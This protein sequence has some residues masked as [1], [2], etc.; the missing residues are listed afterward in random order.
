[1][2]FWALNEVDEFDWIWMDFDGCEWILMDFDE[3][4]WIWM[5][6]D[7]LDGF[8]LIWTELNVEWIWMDLNG[9]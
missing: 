3:F 5:D 9:F 6:L 7:G 1:M 8:G 2:Y 4:D